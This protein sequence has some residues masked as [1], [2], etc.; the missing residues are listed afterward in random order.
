MRYS[1]SRSPLV[2]SITL[3][4]FYSLIRAEVPAGFG[5]E[6]GKLLYQSSMASKSSV[7][8]WVMEGPGQVTFE[9]SWMSMESPNE[10]MHHVYWC[11]ENFPSSFIA[12]WEMQNQDLD[13]GLCI[14]FFA[15]T[16]LGGE[17]IMDPSLP[18]RDGTFSQYNNQALQNYHISYYAHNPKLPARPV[19]R[20][21]KNP[22]KNIVY[23]GPP[24][25]D[26][27]SDRPH[28]I[29]LIKEDAHIRLFVDERPII[30]WVDKGEVNGAP[31]GSGKIGLRQMQW[32]HFRYRNFKVWEVKPA[33]TLNAP[34]KRHI[35]DDSA[36]GADGARLYDVN[37]DGLP[38]ITTGWEEGGITRAYLHPGHDKVTTKWPAVTV[39]ST[40]SVED[41]VFC[42]LDGDGA[43]DVVSSCEGT[44]NSIFFH[45]AP[46][47]DS[48]YL[49]ADLWETK[50]VPVT[51]DLTRWMFALPMQIDGRHG[52]DLVVGSKDHN[53]LVGWLE[54][55]PNPRNMEEWKFHK[56]YEAN[57]I[58]SLVSLDID[59][60]GDLDILT[61]D[62]KGESRG[63]LW[64]ENPGPRKAVGKWKEHRIGG[65]G[66]GEVMFLSVAD[67]NLD[68]NQ[69]I[70]ASLKPDEVYWYECPSDPSK[71]WME[72]MFKVPDPG[73][74]G[75][76]KA[77][78]VGDIDGDGKPDVV[79]SCESAT[80]PKTGV[81]WMSYDVAPT[82]KDWT[83]HD[84]AGPDGIK[85]DRIE[86]LDLDG[87]KDLDVVVCEERHEN[88]GLGLI[89]YENPLR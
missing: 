75:F 61:S 73:K 58:M 41:A 59:K 67:M 87:D 40:P 33:S 23:E 46:K 8:D 38:D 82:D 9:D 28:K 20:L 68:G 10:E 32:T 76:A 50:A 35:I 77:V 80:P 49:N 69:D 52:I 57:W 36:R 84:I 3:I 15:A 79:Y 53:G 44:T 16:G 88:K 54:A 31:L 60:D 22:G 74:V 11:P 13:A 56:L 42:D 7:K 14:V 63:V 21:R 1:S 65:E 17:D 62:R 27:S 2:V 85:F 43:V 26:V 71:P 81:F 25:I 37:G 29:T 39:G 83:M 24:G 55:P 64:L 45:W 12:Q 34:W 5:I 66:R 72:H 86:L 6:P 51:V 78:R 18:K 4:V 48:N 70:T 19:A 30:D 47:K 89:W